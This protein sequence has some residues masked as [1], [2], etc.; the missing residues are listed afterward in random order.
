MPDRLQL[1]IKTATEY[2]VGG[3]D[4]EIETAEETTALPLVSLVGHHAVCERNG[5]HIFIPSG[6]ARA[7][8][9]RS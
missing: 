8:R 1:V 4:G 7:P 5:G 6:S 9:H 3:P 2:R